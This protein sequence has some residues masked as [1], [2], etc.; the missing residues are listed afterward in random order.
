MCVCACAWVH[1]CV[2]MRVHACVCVIA[3]GCVC[4]GMCAR[5]R[6]CF[7]PNDPNPSGFT[8][9]NKCAFLLCACCMTLAL[10]LTSPVMIIVPLMCS[11]FCPYV[12]SFSVG[13]HVITVNLFSRVRRVFSLGW[14][15]KFIL[16]QT[17]GRFT[18]EAESSEYEHIGFLGCDAVWFLMISVG[19]LPSSYRICIKH[20]CNKNKQDA[21][22]TF[23]LF[24]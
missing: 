23:N 3:C 20:S 24:R 15:T 19:S 5:V 7:L 2:R 4:V 10:D 6:A 9:K 18:F 21:V 11:F 22:F 17:P 13:S 1:V 12:T 8:S 14:E 16:V